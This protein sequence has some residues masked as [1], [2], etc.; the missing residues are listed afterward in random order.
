[1]DG[2]RRLPEGAVPL[3]VGALAITAEAVAFIVPAPVRPRTGLATGIAVALLVLLWCAR[4]IR[5]RA[6][7]RHR[8]RTADRTGGY[9]GDQGGE[10]F[11]PGYLEGLPAGEACGGAGSVRVEEAWVFARHGYGVGWLTR[12]LEIPHEVA[13]ALVRAARE[14]AAGASAGS[15]GA[16]A[17]GLE[18]QEQ[19]AQQQIAAEQDHSGPS[20]R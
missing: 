13:E 5:R 14:R 1:M 15:A 10:W 6:A 7:A 16:Q 19:G 2:T 4:T 17:D 3:V 18:Q 11:P 8:S 20:A 9:E 12:H